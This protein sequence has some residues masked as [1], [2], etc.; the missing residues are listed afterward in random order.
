[1]LDKAKLEV[2]VMVVGLYYDLQVD[3]STQLWQEFGNNI[4]H[5][6][7]ANGVS[8]AYYWSLILRY[9][10]GN[11]GTMVPNVGPKADFVLYQNPK[12]VENN[13]EI[14]PSVARI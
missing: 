7:F 14:F 6:S 12:M 10:Y 9:V 11:E 3:Y 1:M 13:S 2:Y 4:A 8:C 5:T